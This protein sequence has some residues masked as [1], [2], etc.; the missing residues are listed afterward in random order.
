MLIVA[1]HLPVIQIYITFVFSKKCLAHH[2]S[3]SY[4]IRR[5]KKCLRITSYLF[6]CFI[7]SAIFLLLSI[8]TYRVIVL[9][10]LIFY[11]SLVCSDFIYRRLL[12]YQV[13]INIFYNH[14]FFSLITY[15]DSRYINF[16]NVYYVLILWDQQFWYK[17]KTAKQLAVR[18]KY[19]FFHIFF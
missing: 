13:I 2:E 4:Q 9:S 5:A 6:I 7:L 14:L 15:I 12:C 3:F 19:L 17:K 1:S 16:L 8:D 11:F 10:A 18:Q